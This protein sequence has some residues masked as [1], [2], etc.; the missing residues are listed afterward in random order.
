MMRALDAH[1]TKVYVFP[2]MNTFM[3]EHPLTVPQLKTLT[4]TLG[5]NVV[6]PIGKVLACGDVGK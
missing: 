5:Y 1:R 3:F 6:G 2:A 4:D